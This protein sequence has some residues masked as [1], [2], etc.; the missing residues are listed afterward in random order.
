SKTL[1]PGYRVGWIAPGKYYEQVKQIKLFHAMSCPAITAEAIAWF[2]ET[3]RYDRHLHKM[4]DILQTNAQRFINTI[5]EYF[6]PGTRVSRPRGGLVLWIELP[7]PA[8]TM[9]LYEAA[10]KEKISIAPGRLFTLQDQFN[11]C[12]RVN[13]ALPWNEKTEM[14]LRTLGRLAAKCS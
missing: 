11:N 1:A 2:L 5:G 9:R 13:Y 3:N 6:P 10:M 4:R 14:A 7:P 12:F 8:N